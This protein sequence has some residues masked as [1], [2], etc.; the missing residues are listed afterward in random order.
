MIACEAATF[1]PSA[2]ASWVLENTEFNEG[3]DLREYEGFGTTIFLLDSGSVDMNNSVTD[4]IV[5]LRDPTYEDD[6]LFTCTVDN[7]VKESVQSVRLRVK[8][9]LSKYYHVVYSGG[10]L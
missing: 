4:A 6:G 5:Q 9:K 1:P 7:G 2:S 3:V 10:R 8:C